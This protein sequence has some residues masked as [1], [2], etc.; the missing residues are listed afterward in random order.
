MILILYIT[1]FISL[2][3]FNNSV[4][5]FTW[6]R[7]S[8]C[9]TCRALFAAGSRDSSR[10]LFQCNLC[11]SEILISSNESKHCVF[12]LDPLCQLKSCTAYFHPHLFK[13]MMWKLFQLHWTHV[14]PFRWATK[15]HRWYFT[16][17]VY[18][19]SN[20]LPDEVPNKRGRNC[21]IWYVQKADR[22][23]VWRKTATCWTFYDFLNNT[24]SLRFMVLHIHYMP[25]A[26][27]AASYACVR[28][29][30]F[31]MASNTMTLQ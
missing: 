22:M 5:L 17:R 29:H 20:N 1:T 12:C 24:R 10:F 30:C 11:F 7:S 3:A 8:F 18:R 16:S 2:N 26:C 4:S 13:I 27:L 23:C 9:S 15:D 31:I 19:R 25:C 14:F 6:R 28:V 21:K